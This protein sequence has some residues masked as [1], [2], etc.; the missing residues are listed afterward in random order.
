MEPITGVSQQTIDAINAILKGGGQPYT[1]EGGVRKDITVATGLVG[2]NLE[3]AAKL[4]VPVITPVRNRIPRIANTRGGSAANWKVITALDTSR[5]D[6]FTAEGTKAGTIS[7]SVTDK[8]A[9]YKTISKG[10]FVSFQAQWAGKNFED[11]KARAI[12]RLLKTVMIHEEQ[13]LLGGR[14]AALGAVTAP[15]VVSTTG[16]T[17]ADNTY[18]VFVRAI[19]NLGR[20]KKSTGTGT[21]AVDS[22]ANKITASTPWVEGAVRYEWYV[23]TAGAEKL[24]ATTQINSVSLSSLLGTGALV[25][26]VADNSADTLAFDGLITQLVAGTAQVTT[27]ATGCQRR[28]DG[29]P[30]V[31]HRRH[32]AEHL[33]QRQGQSRVDVH[34]QPTGH[35]PDQPRV[36]GERRPDAVHDERQQ[37]SREDHRRLSGHALPQ[38]DDR[39]SARGHRAPVSAGRDDLDPDRRDAVPGIGYRKPDRD[40]DAQRLHAARLPGRCAEVGVRGPRRRGPEG[41]LPGRVR[42]H[43][44]LQHEEDGVSRR[45]PGAWRVK[46]PRVW[47]L[48]S[49]AGA[50]DRPHVQLLRRHSS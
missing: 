22:N 8:N 32:P 5:V 7:Y 41:V 12:V 20:G 28:R 31:G 3:P 40:R 29:L 14:N 6:V 30:A 13:G 21:G 43:P 49:A 38:Q 23:G 10:D 35:P 15:T 33:G 18:N 44:Q 26:G 2:Y 46:A 4:L 36:G 17:I 39:S 1:G 24:E 37:R 50:L 16:G 42:R 27:L 9:A 45:R 25:S 48:L 19:T 47:P 34:E 11:V